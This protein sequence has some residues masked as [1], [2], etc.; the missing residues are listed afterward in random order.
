MISWLIANKEWIFS[1][2]GGVLIS[3]AIPFFL[4]FFPTREERS[5]R[6]NKQASTRPFPVEICEALAA[7]P[8]LHQEI[9]AGE[10]VGLTVRWLVALENARRKEGGKVYL[11]LRDRGHYPWV[12]CEVLLSEYPDLLLATAGT[13]FWINGKISEVSKGSIELADA[14]LVL[15]S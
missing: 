13:K 11:M 15:A 7:T 12:N 6:E 2:I 4:R 1:G 5:L 10:Y 3:V 8:P 14:H 9:R